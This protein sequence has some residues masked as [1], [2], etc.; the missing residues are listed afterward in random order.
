MSSKV[1]SDDNNRIR[2]TR[3]VLIIFLVIP[4]LLFPNL[5]GSIV[6]VSKLQP[7][8]KGKN[9][10]AL[11]V[12]PT[13]NEEVGEA[14]FVPI[15]WTSEGK[16]LSVDSIFH[17]GTQIFAGHEWLQKYMEWH[18]DM[19]KK[20]PDKELFENP[21]APKVL[22]VYSC[23]V[24][25]LNDRVTRHHQM[26]YGAHRSKR[27]ILFK[28]FTTADLSTFV[29]P[30]LVNWTV[31]NHEHPALS[32]CPRISTHTETFIEPPIATLHNSSQHVALRVTDYYRTTKQ[33][34]NP[35]VSDVMI[36]AGMIPSL[37]H[38]CIV[39][40]FNRL[41]LMNDNCRTRTVV[42]ILFLSTVSRCC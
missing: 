31:P 29:V 27:V 24:G 18:D 37:I 41:V 35:K 16:A 11:T 22:I 4:L 28:W 13:I 23:G 2:S 33:K 40:V 17:N 36:L 12:A 15:I 32:P 34:R 20:Y 8:V 21:N 19:R 14:S 6:Q 3:K 42:M 38:T 10:M 9:V 25:G 5:L 39:H 26:V 1:A 7:L 30:N